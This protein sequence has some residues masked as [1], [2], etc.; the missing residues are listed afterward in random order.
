MTRLCNYTEYCS[1][2]G[3]SMKDYF[4]RESY[5]GKDKIVAYLKTKGK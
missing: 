3:I 2:N 1:P 5:K 4:E